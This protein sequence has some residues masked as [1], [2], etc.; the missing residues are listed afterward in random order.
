MVV[1]MNAP[2]K[3]GVKIPSPEEVREHYRVRL[4]WRW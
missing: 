2:D 4:T 1:T 3:E